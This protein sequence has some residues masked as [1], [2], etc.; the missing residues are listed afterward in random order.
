MELLGSGCG[1]KGADCRGKRWPRRKQQK[2]ERG[3][4]SHDEARPSLLELSLCLNGVQADWEKHE[5]DTW[6]GKQLA[7]DAVAFFS[8]DHTLQ[9]WL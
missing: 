1:Q 8:K 2:V 4:K 6:E 3:K 7:G 9:S 5:M